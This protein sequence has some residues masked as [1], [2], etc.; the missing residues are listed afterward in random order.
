M[1]LSFGRGRPA[2]VLENEVVILDWQKVKDF[3]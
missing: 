3:V 1:P 2:L